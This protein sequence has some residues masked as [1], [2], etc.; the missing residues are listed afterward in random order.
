MRRKTVSALF[1]C[2]LIIG[3]IEP[4]TFT[5]EEPVELLVVDGRIDQSAGPY[6]LRL[7]RTSTFGKPPIPVLDAQ[8]T[9]YDDQGQQEDYTFVRPG[10]YQSNGDIVRGEPGRTYYIEIRLDEQVYQSR[11]QTMPRLIR[12][13]SVYFETKVETIVSEEGTI[14]EDR[15]INVYV[16]TPAKQQ[17]QDARFRWS[18]DVNYSVIEPNC[19]PLHSPKSC[20]ITDTTN[21]QDIKLF[22]S[23]NTETNQLSRFLVATDDTR[24][25]Y[26]FSTRYYINIY[27]FSMTQEAYEYWE[28]VRIIAN[29]EGTI[30]DPPPAPIPGNMYNT[31]DQ[32]ETVL[33]FFEATAIDT[34][35]TVLFRGDL[36]PLPISDFCGYAIG[37]QPSDPRACCGCLLLDNSSLERPDYWDD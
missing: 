37:S 16:D 17:N 15:L 21:T 34:A 32:D 33:G 5:P 25:Q 30:F 27:Q 4:F 14:T 18:S 22:S 9:I 28:D 24:P 12:A 10:V 20:Y 23:E 13:D 36:A 31:D 7:S 19:G 35:R 29:Q 1:P 3:C 26:A 8:I 11:P 2:F 6:V